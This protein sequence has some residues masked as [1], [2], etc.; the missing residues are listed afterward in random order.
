MVTRRL[1]PLAVLAILFGLGGC[2]A[3]DRGVGG[4]ASLSQAQDSQPEKYV[5]QRGDELQIKF[6]YN[7]ELND[8]VQVRPDGRISLQLV[9]DIVAAGL[10]P[11]QLD[12]ALTRRYSEELKSPVVSVILRSFAAQRVYVAGEVNR[13]GL[14]DLT[15]GM[16]PLEAVIKS[17]GWM[18]TGKPEA[19]LVIRKGPDN[20]PFPIRVD[21][22]EA[23]RGTASGHT[24]QLQPFDI[25]YVP[26]TFI[27]E[28][29]KFVNQ[30][31][32]KLLLFRGVSLG[33]SYELRDGSNS[34]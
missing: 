18:E 28:A 19:T 31:V 29:N 22:K 24:L 10:T 13:Q 4:P 32:E 23:F 25:V 33:F 12:D 15:P 16:T 7:P 14:V 6:F 27:A 2:A 20:R 21:L 1:Y 9:D 26:K 3:T 8:T 5:I 34:Y 30:Y 17:E 11:S